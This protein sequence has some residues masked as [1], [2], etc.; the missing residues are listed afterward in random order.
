[1]GFPNSEKRLSRPLS[2]PVDLKYVELRLPGTFRELCADAKFSNEQ[3]GRIVRCIALGT[4]SLITQDIEPEV[5]YYRQ[6][7]RKRLYDKLRKIKS[8]KKQAGIVDDSP[9]YPSV[10][11]DLDAHA[12]NGL[13]R[14][15]FVSRRNLAETFPIINAN[16]EHSSEDSQDNEQIPEN[17]HIDVPTPTSTPAPAP[18]P[19]PIPM[20]SVPTQVV[21][22]RKQRTSEE[23]ARDNLANDLFSCAGGSEGTNME[24]KRAVNVASASASVDTRS[25]AAWI[26]GKFAIFWA[27]YPRKVAKS[28]AVKAFTKLIKSQADV[29]KFM[30]LTLASLEYWKKQDQW[31]KDDG[32]F[33]PYPASWLNAG[34][35]NDCENG[36][37][38]K[39]MKLMK[40]VQATFLRGDAES[41]E[42]LLKRMT[43]G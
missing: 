32:K 24:R 15:G 26:P 33:I 10:M 39:S 18:T 4:D 5:F 36:D 19:T 42:D 43:G 11:K 14:E 30:S 25:D 16:V 23:V 27:Q 17:P 1:M 20:T 22:K 37:V 40:P 13:P 34:H 3:I 8:R 6:N 7:Q 31:T 38:D 35:W 21:R 41:N 2:V 28:D 12:L 9:N 29:E